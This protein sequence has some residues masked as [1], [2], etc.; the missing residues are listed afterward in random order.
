MSSDGTS[1][2]GTASFEGD[3]AYRRGGFHAALIGETLGPKRAWRVASK[4]GFGVHATAWAARASAAARAAISTHAV[5]IHRADDSSWRDEVETLVQLR[6]DACVLRI[7]T[8]FEHR[9]PNGVHG[10]I[11]SELEGCSLDAAVSARG[12]L[13]TWVVLGVARDLLTGVGAL[14]A[15]G[16][17]HTDIKPDNVLL[18]PALSRALVGAPRELRVFSRDRRPRLARPLEPPAPLPE[19][20]ADAA[21]YAPGAFCVIGDLGNAERIGRYPPDPG[22]IQPRLYRAPEVVAYLPHTEAVDVYAAGAVVHFAATARPMLDPDGETNEARNADHV[23]LIA[24][25]LGPFP[26]Y[27]RQ[28]SFLAR[29]ADDVEFDRAALEPSPVEWLVRML[30]AVDPLERPRAALAAAAE[31]SAMVE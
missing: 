29:A 25:V 17:V 3:K 19:L 11:V 14:H 1:D 24:R 10:C 8:S 5:K 9:G 7:T 13:P 30:T 2:D 12:A 15:R 26:E 28:A 6:G 4:I 27:M 20:P 22:G 16:F 31:S 18:R 23:R 21:A